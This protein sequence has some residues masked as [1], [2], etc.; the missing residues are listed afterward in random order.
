MSNTVDFAFVYIIEAVGRGMVKVGWAVDPEERLKTLQSGCP[1]KLVLRQKIGTSRR[2]VVELEQ[3]THDWL[4][5]CWVRG[6]W[7]VADSPRIQSI[8]ELGDCF[9]V[10]LGVQPLEAIRTKRRLIPMSQ[11]Q[12]CVF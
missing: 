9:F 12:E 3:V 7:F 8:L 1:D 11:T 4:K 5:D 10:P 6:E 2:R